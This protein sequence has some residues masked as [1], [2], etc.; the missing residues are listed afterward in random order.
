MGNHVNG[1][2][3]GFVTVSRTSDT[4]GQTINID[5]CFVPAQHALT[6]KHPAVSGSSGRLVVERTRAP[7]RQPWPSEVFTDPACAYEDAMR[8]FVTTANA[9]Y[10]WRDRTHA[11]ESVTRA[12]QRKSR[13]IKML[14]KTRPRPSILIWTRA[15]VSTDVNPCAVNWLPWSVLNMV[16]V[17]L[18][19]ACCSATRQKLPSRLLTAAKQAR[20]D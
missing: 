8:A 18:S 20:S 14:S 1:Q 17:P 9:R 15:V 12:Q 11:G 6:D 4:P 13:S 10:A 7:C 19:S 3:K 5:L 16:G 2:K